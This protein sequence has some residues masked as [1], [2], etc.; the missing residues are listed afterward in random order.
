[1]KIMGLQF[2]GTCCH[3]ISTRP[4]V[5]LNLSIFNEYSIRTTFKNRVFGFQPQTS[6]LHT[7]VSDVAV[8][9]LKDHL[10]HVYTHTLGL[11]LLGY[12]STKSF[13]WTP[14]TS[15]DTFDIFEFNAVTLH[16]LFTS[17]SRDNALPT[18]LSTTNG[19]H[20]SEHISFKLVD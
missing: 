1:M 8:C 14:N 4:F 20:L 5:S 12:L 9:N 19:E 16:H 2:L 18:V 15:S 7:I 3:L 11:Q 17:R 6:F 13:D 10:I